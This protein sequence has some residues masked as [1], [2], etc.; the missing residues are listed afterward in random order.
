M[1][2]RFVVV[3]A[4]ALAIGI[5]LAALLV[6]ALA[7]CDRREGTGVLEGTI[8]VANEAGDSLTAIDVGTHRHDAPAWR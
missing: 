2:R 4:L 8:W 5:A 7:G 3:A 1:S 6:S